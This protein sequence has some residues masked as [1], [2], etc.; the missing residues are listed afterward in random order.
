MNGEVILGCKNGRKF[1]YIDIGK[2]SVSVF[3]G[4]HNGV[5]VD[6]DSGIHFIVDN[7][8]SKE[9][10]YCFLGSPAI[11]LACCVDFTCVL[12][13][14]GNVYGNGK[15]NNNTLDFVETSSLKDLKIGN[16]ET[17]A[18]LTSDGPVAKVEMDDSFCSFHEVLKGEEIKDVSCSKFALFLTKSY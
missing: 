16:N 12:T 6:E 3:A 14:S 5:I 4:K 7:D 13:V 18:T 9:Q 15:L 17:C 2:K 1:L 10:N 11:D 8:L